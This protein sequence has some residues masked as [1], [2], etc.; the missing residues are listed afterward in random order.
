MNSL[1]NNEKLLFYHL[2]PAEGLSGM[3]ENCKTVAMKAFAKGRK[4]R[5][6]GSHRG[7]RFNFY[8]PVGKTSAFLT[9][10]A[11]SAGS[12]RTAKSSPFAKR[13]A[14]AE[15]RN[16]RPVFLNIAFSGQYRDH[17][18]VAYGFEEYREKGRK[19]RKLLFFKVRDG[20]SL[21]TRWLVYR[22]IFGIFATTFR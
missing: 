5:T 21:D 6:G 1:Q 14:I 19:G 10:C 17:T 2:K 13:T 20:Y 4:G 15:I 16:R 11:K 3:L 7:S 9:A 8:I 18:I 22:R 12:Q